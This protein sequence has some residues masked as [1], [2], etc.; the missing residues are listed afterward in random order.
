MTKRKILSLDYDNCYC[1]A[2]EVGVRAE[3]QQNAVTY[4]A[5]PILK[6]RVKVISELCKTY[7]T[8]LTQDADVVSVYVGSA[9]QSYES[10][11]LYQ[12]K[13]KNGSVFLALQSLCE[14][15]SKIDEKQWIFEPFLLAD[16]VGNR[17]ESLRNMQLNEDEKPSDRAFIDRQNKMPI[18]LDKS[19]IPLILEQMRDAYEQYPDDELE[20]HFI[21]D[22]EKLIDD[23]N[24]NL[25]EDEMPPGMR[26]LVSRLDY[27]SYIES[28]KEP[29]IVKVFESS[30]SRYQSA[31]LTL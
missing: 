18:N 15:N 16:S 11:L 7:I 13:H 1:I 4:N 14:E 20:F 22:A 6:D 9:R 27:I 24:K 8:N 21:D 30:A 29:E 23:I 25:S 3:F 12:R 19:K 26:L 17:G 28:E 2:T 10:D 31:A 5:H